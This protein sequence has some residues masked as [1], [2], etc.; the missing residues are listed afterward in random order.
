MKDYEV[1]FPKTVP[2]GIVRSRP[3]DL[4]TITGQC[5]TTNPNKQYDYPKQRV[6]KTHG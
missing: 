4:V 1:T 3:L 2:T 6:M 5:P